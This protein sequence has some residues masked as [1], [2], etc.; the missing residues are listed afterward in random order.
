M[1]KKNYADVQNTS[2]RYLRFLKRKIPTLERQPQYIKMSAAPKYKYK[3][4]QF[5][6]LAEMR[7]A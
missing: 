5:S 2:T 7:I 1:A 3:L 4:I 6:S